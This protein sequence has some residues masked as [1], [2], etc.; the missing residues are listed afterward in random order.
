MAPIKIVNRRALVGFSGASLLLIER[1][2]K[3]VVR[4]QAM[5]PDQS[6]RLRAQCARLQSAAADGIPC[7]AVIDEGEELG[8]YWFEMEYV[9]GASLATVVV[10]GYDSDWVGMTAQIGALVQRF[11][12]AATVLLPPRAFTDKLAD[13]ARRCA[14]RPIVA[15]L[16]PAI[17]RLAAEL[18]GMDWE[19]IHDGPSHGDLTLENILRRPDGTLVFID[20]DVPDQGSWLLDVGKL[21]QDVK[22]QW[23]LRRLA[24][25]NPASV[26]LLNAQLRIARVAALCDELFLPWVPGGRARVSQFAAF[27]LMRTLPYATD[28]HVPAFVLSRIAALLGS[29]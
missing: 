23:F 26:E 6:A 27:H 19:G 10:S 16:L 13:I 22:G 7:P 14:E 2:D 17:E 1:G 29:R 15:P 11:R 21:Y 25:A 18:A 24:L 12:G 3:T 8:R 4:K 28:P 20:F 9:P 5:R